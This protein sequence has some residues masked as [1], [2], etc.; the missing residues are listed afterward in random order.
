MGGQRRRCC[1]ALAAAAAGGYLAVGAESGVVNIYQQRLG[2][3]MSRKPDHLKA[4]MNVTTEID[5]L[6]F[7]QDSQMLA[8]GSRMVKDSVK[9][10]H[11]PSCTVFQNWPTA[12]TPLGYASS[13]EFSPNGGLLAIGNAKGRVLL[14]RLK[15]YQNS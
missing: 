5:S 4:V 12:R 10:V 6:C 9:L 11:L 7:N 8:I 2:S 13:I 14:Y 1:G 15:H 3:D